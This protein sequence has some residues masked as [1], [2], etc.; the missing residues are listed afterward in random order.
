MVPFR[1]GAKDSV[2]TFGTSSLV[3][4][5]TPRQPA[6]AGQTSGRVSLLEF[7]TPGLSNPYPVDVEDVTGMIGNWFPPEGFP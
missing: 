7:Q 1:N 3:S 6:S 2:V 5:Q 4:G